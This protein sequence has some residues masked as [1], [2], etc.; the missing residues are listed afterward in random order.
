[1]T[2]E[3]LREIEEEFDGYTGDAHDAIDRL[4]A[5]VRR[6]HAALSSIVEAESPRDMYDTAKGALGS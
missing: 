5:E 6:L 4:I 1:M 2:E 3:Q